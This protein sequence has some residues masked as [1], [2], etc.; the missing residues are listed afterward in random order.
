V[1][2]IPLAALHQAG[3]MTLLTLA[4]I[5]AHSVRRRI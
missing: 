2:P 3:A 4:L 5:A 1:V